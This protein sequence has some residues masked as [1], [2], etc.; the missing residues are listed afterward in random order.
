MP[1]PN[2]ARHNQVEALELRVH[3]CI[4]A[5]HRVGASQACAGEWAVA[6]VDLLQFVRCQLTGAS[7]GKHPVLVVVR[8]KFSLSSG[9]DFLLQTRW[10]IH[11][12]KQNIRKDYRTVGCG[13]TPVFC[14]V[15]PL[16]IQLSAFSSQSRNGTPFHRPRCEGHK[17]RTYAEEEK[18]RLLND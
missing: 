10:E 5:V 9:F 14:A 16:S 13:S 18:N 1:S 8:H 11:C 3:V 2:S 7:A 15:E 12:R 6:P 4:G 17:K